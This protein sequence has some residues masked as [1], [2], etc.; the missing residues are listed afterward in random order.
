VQ[1]EIRDGHAGR[2][3]LQEASTWGADL[4]VIGTHGFGFFEQM[5]MG[6]T[7]LHVLREARGAVVVVPQAKEDT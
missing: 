5:L 2:Q 4:V 3:I 6:S 7:T 1:A